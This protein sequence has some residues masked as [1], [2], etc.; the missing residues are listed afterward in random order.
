MSKCRWCGNPTDS[1]L[2][3][4]G[5]C[6]NKCKSEFKVSKKNRGPIYKFFTKVI[7]GFL[8]LF[9]LMAICSNHNKSIKNNSSQIHKEQ[10]NN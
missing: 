5:F 7:W 1:P 2:I 6:S 10:N 9:A 3:N 8:I 4:S